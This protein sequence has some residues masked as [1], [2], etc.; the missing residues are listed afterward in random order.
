MEKA[1]LQAKNLTQQL[2]TFSKGGEPVK[3]LIN[4][5]EAVKNSANFSLRGSK[6]RCDFSISEDLLYRPI[7]PLDFKIYVISSNYIPN[8]FIFSKKI[9]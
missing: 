4:L 2:L 6:V 9:K 1:S 3:K 8:Y 7:P 5:A